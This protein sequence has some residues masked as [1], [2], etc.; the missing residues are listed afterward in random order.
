MTDFKEL[1]CRGVESDVLDYKAPVNWTLLSKAQKAKF[2]RHALAFAN[3]RGGA[4]VIGVREDVNGHPSLYEGLSDE[5][6]HSFDPSTVGS[7]INSHVDP[8]I[9]LSVERPVVDGKRYAVL[10]IRPFQD[11]PHVCVHSIEDE[12]RSGVF[13]IRSASASSRPAARAGEMHDLVRRALRNQRE[14]L[15]GLLRDILGD[16]P[17]RGRAIPGCPDNGEQLPP[18]YEESVSYFQKRQNPH[19]VPGTPVLDLAIMPLECEQTKQLSLSSLRA[20]AESALRKTG[21]ESSERFLNATDLSC[22][23]ATN[24]SLRGMNKEHSRFW[25]L[26]QNGLL[27]F[28]S[29]IDG[30]V[31]Y[32]ALRSQLLQ[33]LEPVKNYYAALP[34]HCRKLFVQ[35]TIENSDGLDMVSANGSVSSCRIG[36]VRIVQNFELDNSENAPADPIAQIMDELSVRFNAPTDQKTPFEAKK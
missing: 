14:M 10:I 32:N 35:L 12:L 16:M 4:I 21:Q 22:S 34:G 2:V 15:A 7:Y 30:A 13:Y 17:Q 19:F 25:Q 28:R 1:I 24:V 9:D 27:H 8:A 6:C 5:E 26:F 18:E 23:Y 20:A 36:K 29:V 33:L 3:T 31:E 11:I